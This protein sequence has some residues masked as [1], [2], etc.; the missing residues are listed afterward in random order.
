M[1]LGLSASQSRVVRESEGF[2]FSCDLLKIK[3]QPHILDSVIKKQTVP[4][5]L[6]NDVT[7]FTAF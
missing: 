6:G 1:G 3:I 5:I 2:V 7:G 4:V